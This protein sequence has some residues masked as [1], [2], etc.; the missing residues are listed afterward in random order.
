MG[1]KEKMTLEE[2]RKIMDEHMGDYANCRIIGDD[3]IVLKKRELARLKNLENNYE[4]VYEEFRKLEQERKRCRLLEDDEVVVRKSQMVNVFAEE[5]EELIRK[6]T[7]ISFAKILVSAI[8]AEKKDE[9][10][11]IK[12]VHDTVRD[13]LR[14]HFGVELEDT[15]GQE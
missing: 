4:Q 6:T 15:N 12:D 13:I 3:E 9:K 8:W 2:M 7:A 1:K 10:I 5:F 14:M 11:R